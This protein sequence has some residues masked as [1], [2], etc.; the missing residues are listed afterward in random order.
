MP[1]ARRLPIGAEVQEKGVHFRLWA[2]RHRS[3]QVLLRDT[4]KPIDMVAE[5]EG[6]YSVLVPETGTGTQYWFVVDGQKFPDPASR[7][8]PEGPHGPSQVVDPS[9][10]EWTDQQWSGSKLAGQVIYELHIGT[11]TPEGNWAAAIKKLPYLVDTGVTL[12]EVMPVAEFPGK[13]GWGYDGV[14][15]FAPTRLYG[16][17]DEFRQFVNEAHRLGLGVIL[18]VVYNHFG[19]DGNYIG[20]FS[21]D[22]FTKKYANEWGEAINFDGPHSAPV[23]E[24]MAKNAAYWIDEYHLDGLRLDATQQIFDDSPEHVLTLIGKEVRAAAKGRNTL[25]VNENE[26]QEARLVRSV[27]KGGCG[28]DAIWN[29]DFHHSARVATT[30]HSEAYYSDHKGSA[31]ELLSAV[32]WGFIYQGQRY[33]W[34]KARRGHY[35][36]DLTPPQFITF[37][38]N[39]DQVAN[40]ANGL[41]LHHMTSSGA[42]KAM[43]ALLLLAPNTPMLF[44]GQEFTSSA[45]FLFFA[46]HKPELNTL[47]REGRLKFLAQFPS[48]ATEEMRSILPDPGSVETFE[49]CIL[50]WSEVETNRPMYD[51]HRDLLRLRREEPC[52]RSQERGKFDGAILSQDALVLRFFGPEIDDRLLIINLGRDLQCDPAPEPLLAPPPGCEWEEMWSSE[53]PKYGGLGTPNLDTE[54]FNWR[55]PATAAVVLKP[56]R[57]KT[58][59]DAK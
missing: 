4:T 59:N 10:F 25:I 9:S 44:Q 2:P 14:S 29:D 42:Y 51:L 22:Y 46:D 30:G 16:Q 40:S 32:K 35:S 28:L 23:R 13:F 26:R 24:F 49:K 11:F 47:I 54:E 53:D 15:F 38:Q 48:L 6:Y 37:L 21:E 56:L 31:Q 12:I 19:P 57:L 5:S 18:D 41:R 7:F 27:E 39:H 3:L 43:T 1:V 52:F 33:K 34:Q 58:N 17:P 36:L 8:Q 45:P 20:C 50:D 55:I